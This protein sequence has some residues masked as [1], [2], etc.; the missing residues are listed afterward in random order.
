[1]R[2]IHAVTG[3]FGYSGR[4][5]ASRLLEEG[6][7]VVTLTGS[8][9][10]KSR[11]SEKVKAFPYDFEH[12]H[13][14]AEALEGVSVLYNTYWVRFNHRSFNHAGAVAKSEVLFDAARRAG[15]ERVVHVSITNPS[16]DSPLSYFRG[17]AKVELALQKSGL[18]YAILRPAVLF[19]REDILI[20]NIAWALR[21][22]P[23]FGVFGDG[24]YRLCP[25]HVDDLAAAAV[26]YGKDRKNVVIDAIGPEIF[27]YRELVETIGKFIGFERP[28][29]GVPNRVGW[30]SGW[31][32]G[33]INGDVMITMDEIRGLSSGL[34]HV[35]SE[36]LG[37]THLK[38]WVHANR[39]TL[40]KRYTSELARRV[41]LETAY[42]SN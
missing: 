28:V 18:S 10:R 19:G 30:L 14:M 34:L 25:I 40:G 41:D 33:R 11:L 21:R 7:E 2:N 32:I 3:A 20:N 15:V 24:Q 16:I 39:E 12:P 6:C 13:K 4:Y 9:D 31:L 8:V 22:L 5:I 38:D 35:D 17:K 36:P 29:I 37:F 26:A 27:T 23:V 42:R 1:M